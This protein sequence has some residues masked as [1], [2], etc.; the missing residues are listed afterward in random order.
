MPGYFGRV[1]GTRLFAG[2]A[3]G[4]VRDHLNMPGYAGIPDPAYLV[5]WDF[6]VG[7]YPDLK[8]GHIIFQ[9]SCW[10]LQYTTWVN[11]SHQWEG[12]LFI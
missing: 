1:A 8:P 6:D 7:I 4:G 3:F 11:S 10:Y 9:D 12:V 5:G 2:T